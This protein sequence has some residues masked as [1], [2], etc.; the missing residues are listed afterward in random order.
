MRAR[1]GRPG[2]AFA[3]L[4]G[5]DVWIVDC[6]R[7]R[8]HPTHA[9]LDLALDWIAQVRPRRA[10]MTNLHIDLDYEQLRRELPAN[11]EPA[12]DGLRFEH[13]MAAEFV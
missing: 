8:P 1:P 11:V 3:A 12:F 6:L 4:A 9:H 10:I 13:E 2:R 5:L 7:R